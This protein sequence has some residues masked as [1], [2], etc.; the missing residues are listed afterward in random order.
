MRIA[1]IAPYQG[2]GL[3][4][5]RP[6]VRN[7]SLAPNVKIGL[8]AELLRESSHSVE[9][10]SPGEVVEHRF[11]F[12]PGFQEDDRN[13]PIY[14]GSAFPVRFINGLASSRSLL[15]VFKARH[16]VEPFDV[17]LIYNLKPA[18]ITCADYAIRRLGLPIIL[19][20]EDDAFSDVWGTND[21]GVSSR[22]YLSRAK[23]LLNCVS[24]C[25]AISPY[26]L[27]QA[28]A[29]VPKLLLRGVVS[30]SIVKLSQTSN[31]ARKNWVVFSGTHEETQGLEQMI[32]AWR[33][34]GMPDW[35]LH[36]A[37]QG[38]VTG[39]LRKLAE[40][41]ES[42]VFRGLIDR[43]ENAQLLCTAKI[44]LNPQDLTR[45]AG[46]VFAFKI[47][48]YLAAGLH[49]ITTP[50]GA[51]EQELEA[52]I[53]YISDNSPES[54]A[55]GLK[56]AIETR[57]YEQTAEQAALQSF[58]PSAVTSSLNELLDQVITASRK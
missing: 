56:T 46:N 11:K 8:I 30:E 55:A 24:A 40:G 35:E 1:Y 29:S 23:A 50:R 54:I 22:Y 34:L 16:R 45:I 58:G 44:G 15:R 10:L 38:P 47:I 49:V 4:K 21:S 48:E 20:Y 57:G 36:V 28:P 9:I 26:L 39:L 42:I 13:I 7:L 19:E 18:Q 31:G 14:Y 17:V 3:I 6:I 53:S 37:G 32:K 51:L 27:S 5:R 33:M 52:G 41:D 25:A 2:T 12:Y 43:A